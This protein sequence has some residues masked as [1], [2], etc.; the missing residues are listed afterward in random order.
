MRADPPGPRSRSRHWARVRKSDPRPTASARGGRFEQRWTVQAETWVPLPGGEAAWPQQVSAGRRA[1]PVVEHGGRPAVRLLPGT[2]RLAGRFVWPQRPEVLSVPPEIGLLSLR[3]NGREVSDPRRERDGRLWL[4]AAPSRA[5]PPA[6]PDALTLELARRIDD[7]V[8]LRVRTRLLLEVSGRPREVALGPVLLPGGIPLRIES[9]LPA[10]LAAAGGAPA[11]TGLSGAGGPGN[12]RLQVQ[13]RP[14]RWELAVDSHHP[15]PVAALRLPA[16]AGEAPWPSQEVWVFAARPDLRQVEITGAEPVDPRQTRLPQAWTRLPAYLMHPGTALRR[17]SLRR[18]AAES[19][20]LPRRRAGAASAAAGPAFAALAVLL[21]AAP[22]EAAQAEEPREPEPGGAT[23]GRSALEDAGPRRAAPPPLDPRQAP[24]ALAEVVPGARAAASGGFPPG[25]LLE[26]LEQRLTAPP[27]CAPRC[28]EIP[29][30]VLEVV[31]DALRISLAVDAAVAVA[32]PVPGAQP[33]WSPN[34]V[35]LDGAPLESLRRRDDGSLLALV[36]AGR[37]L[38]RLA[39]PLP[40]AGEVE[41]PLPLRPRLVEAEVDAAWQLEGL[42]ADG[43]PGEQLRLVRTR[44]DGAETAGAALGRSSDGQGS[45][46]PLLRITRTLRFGLDWRV[47][48]ALERIS[49]PGSAV[50]VRVALIPGEAVTSPGLQV[51]DGRVLVALPPGRSRTAWSSTLTPVDRLTLTASEDP[52]ITEVWR[53]QVAPIWH[54]E[55]DGVPPVQ[56]LDASERWLPTYRPWPGEALTLLLSRP[57][58]VPGPT[59]TLDRSQYRVTPG[60]RDSD[61]A[62]TLQLRSSQGGRHRILLPEGATLTELTVDGQ[63]RPL[64]LKGRALELPLVPGSQGIRIEWRAPGPLTARYRAAPVG[65]GSAGVRHRILLPE[66]ATLTALTV[67]GQQRPLA[68][69]GRALELPLVPG[70]QGIRIEWRAPGPL[71]ARYRAAPV[72]LGSAGVN[73]ATEVELSRDRW[74]LWTSGP[75]IGPAVLFWGLLLV[76]A[77]LAA[78]LARAR[79]TPLGFLDW[80]LLTIGLS[81][82]TPWAGALVVLWL[83]ALGLRRRLGAQ[84]RPWRFNLAQLGLVVL[85]LAALIALLTALQQGLLGDPEMQ[86]AGNGSSATELR[87]YLDRHGEQT[88]SV[89]VVS[90]PIWLY[91]AL[92]LA[93]AL[94]LAWRL[95]DWLRWGWRS[96]SE[97]VLWKPLQ[98]RRP[99]PDRTGDQPLSV[100]L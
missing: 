36:P 98:R 65:L 94:W 59:L 5:R 67:D 78:L 86:I 22:P 75:G 28:A 62:L 24:G 47:E 92:M 46:P 49:P 82:V 97:P 15:G 58:A 84:T 54:L 23:S 7:D 96:L 32:L 26:A 50:G 70:S 85:S 14:G 16:S 88:P 13:L 37:H 66:G 72:G 20:R 34:R 48:T 77:V 74:V 61:A 41:L 10:R 45:L 79:L 30:M 8:P 55:A 29:R 57:Q 11:G 51:A 80:L 6:E 25:A 44:P 56:R 9:P 1:L 73:A 18:G 87:W 81:Q 93:W 52:R 17:E 43:R 60:R 71:T 2:H 100:D 91:R 12:A 27:E 39:G 33:G 38:L 3:L 99:R 83:F 53:L 21:T 64:A 69:K 95:L 31:A 35:A 63:Q 68:L 89:T 19:D 90:A 40:A 42:A 4:G 76:L